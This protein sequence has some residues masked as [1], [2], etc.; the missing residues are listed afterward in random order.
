MQ[1]GALDSGNEA[2]KQATDIICQLVLMRRVPQ[3]A[4][5]FSED[6]IIL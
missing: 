4:E 6:K 1:S 2:V 3:I 5:V